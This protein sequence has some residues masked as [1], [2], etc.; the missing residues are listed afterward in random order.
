VG[1]QTVPEPKVGKTRIHLDL[2]VPLAEAEGEV[3]RVVGL[4]ATIL[5]PPVRGA[6][7]RFNFQILADP[8]GTEFCICAED[9]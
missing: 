6:D 9:A 1:L 2:Y 4:G 5:A 3:D 8:V 7:D